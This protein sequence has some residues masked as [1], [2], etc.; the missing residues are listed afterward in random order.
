MRL[1]EIKKP[2]IVLTKEY[3]TDIIYYLQSNIVVEYSKYEFGT[4]ATKYRKPKR[5]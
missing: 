2:S 4:T 5:N 3:Q 1:S